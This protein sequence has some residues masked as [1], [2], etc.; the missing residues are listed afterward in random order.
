MARA[1]VCGKETSSERAMRAQIL[2]V[3]EELCR[4]KTL[5]EVR[6]WYFDSPPEPVPGNRAG[7]AG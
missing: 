1:A 3:L 6:E 2:A 4:D 5:R 7:L